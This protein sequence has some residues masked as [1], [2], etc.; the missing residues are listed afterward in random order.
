M[1]EALLRDVVADLW[2]SFRYDSPEH[3][4]PIL[5]EMISKVLIKE[6]LDDLK[7]DVYVDELIIKWEARRK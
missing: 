5:I 2:A 7:S 6:F 1:S 4:A 3:H